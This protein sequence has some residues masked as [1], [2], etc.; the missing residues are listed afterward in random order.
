MCP[1]SYHHN[2]I[3]EACELGPMTYDCTLLDCIVES[4]ECSNCK[5][6]AMYM[7]YFNLSFGTIWNC[8]S[9]SFFELVHIFLN[10]YRYF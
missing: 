9:S 7:L 2:G 4:P 6:C 5:Q 8:T 3:T 10:W 1:S